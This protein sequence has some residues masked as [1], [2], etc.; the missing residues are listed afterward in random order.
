MDYNFNKEQKILSKTAREFLKKEAPTTLVQDLLTDKKG[1]SPLIWDKISELGWLGLVFNEEYGGIG[2]NFLDIAILFEEIGRSV[3][4]SPFFST[5][6]LSG[7]LIQD[8]GS[9]EIK[10]KYLPLISDGKCISTLAFVGKKGIYGQNEIDL[11]ATET[12]D[13]YVLN[14]SALFV[15]YAH[16]ADMIICAANMTSENNKTTL[17]MIDSK[18]DGLNITLLKTISG[19]CMDCMINLN[20]VKVSRDQIVGSQGMGWDQIEKLWPRI[21]A[22]QSCECVGGMQRV[23]EMTRDY[24]NSRIQFGKPL[25]ALQVVQHMCVDMAMKAEVSRHAA[26]AAAWSISEGLESESENEAAI[27]KSWCSEAYKDVVAIAHQLTGAIGFTEEFDLHLYTKNAKKL[28]IFF[29]DGAYQRNKV[30]DHLGL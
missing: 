16:V 28:E 15:P 4:P 30:A 7:L 2:G 3:L 22:A 27:A 24:V 20:N 18:T 29:G 13:G 21:I 19:D 12:N 10:N 23:M 8:C 11:H 5:I 1:Y 25:G 26:Y 17:F 6:I 14:G 9:N